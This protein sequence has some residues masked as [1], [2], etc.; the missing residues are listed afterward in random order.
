MFHTYCVFAGAP[1]TVQS[2][3]LVDLLGVEHI[4]NAQAMLS[5]FVGT[6][7]LLA[8]PFA[9]MCESVTTSVV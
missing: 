9:G 7:A 4:A 1:Q 3:L 2:T 6:S 8:T 5:M